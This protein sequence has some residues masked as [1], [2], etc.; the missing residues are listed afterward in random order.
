MSPRT[1]LAG[2]ILLSALPLLIVEMFPSWLKLVM[3]PASY[4]V[5]HNIVEFF[6]IMVSL[7]MFG[8]GW[9]TYDQS[10]NRH[11]LFLS[12]AFLAI[13][14]MDFMH[15]MSMPAMP[16]FITPNLPNKSVQFWI[17][18]RLLQAVAFLI[19]AF[20]YPEKPSRWLS[21]GILMTSVLLLCLVVF[22]GIIFFPTDMPAAFVVGVGLTP[23]KKFSEYLIILLLCVATA[24][25][26][27]RMARTGYRLLLYY[28]AAFVISIFS[29]IPFALYTRMFDTYN[30]LGHIY[31]VAAFSLIYYG[32]FKA[33]V[34]EPYIKLAEMGEELKR[35]IA[36]RL[37]AEQE[38]QKHRDHLEELV[39]GRT[40]QLEAA[41][42]QLQGEIAERGRME[43]A[44]RESEERLRFALETSHTG[45]WD[46]DLVDHTTFRSL[47]HDRIF[48]YAELLPQ[49]TYE[50]FLEHV[51]PED[52]AMVSAKF[53]RAVDS[54]SDWSFE[55][56][57]RR[58][59][60]QVRW[61]WAAGHHRR[62]GGDLLRRMAGVVQDITERKQ[63]EEALRQRTL[64]LQQLTETL[65][66]E[67]QERTE[68]LEAMNEELRKEIDQC[69]R[70]DIEL[71]KSQEDLRRLSLE[72]LNAHEKE[73]RL[74]AREIHDSIGSS[75]VAAKFKVETALTEVAD[76]SP[77]ITTALKNV[78]PIVQGAIDDAR[79]I[80]MNLR[81]SMLDDLGLLATIRWLCRQFESTYSDIRIRQSI[82][83]DEDEVS[84]S[85]KTVVFRVL[86]EGLNNI[87]KHSKTK[88]VMLLLRK[89]G[90]VLK[91]VIRDYGQ[92]FDLSKA[93]SP[94]GTGHGFGLKSMRE[95][96]ELSGG[97]FDI[98]SI[99]GKGT[100][101][102][103]SWPLN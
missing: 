41:N 30:V 98:K 47:E 16:A 49:W 43:E 90:H 45:A 32:I 54:Q 68:Q 84:D 46:L 95:R 59:D 70:I 50:M 89:A 1:I 34:K 44:L 48:G 92:G 25:Y 66:Q 77:E 51:L 33:S 26:W 27:K 69:Q 18:V 42:A 9:Y 58:T 52:R 80:Q 24:A 39:K 37:L 71:R 28:L 53:Q 97:S 8:L 103:A 38:L 65:E 61:I 12:T 81:P 5:F 17:A 86:Q 7:S 62:D 23:F 100:I 20:V 64:E 14:I 72:L 36:E 85:L 6:S 4:L 79:R 76:K 2:T 31:K 10:K 35:D 19:S 73:R 94:S 91:L 74:V 22:T 3:D 101:I 56:R 15:T 13:G 57:I 55:C 29:E 87:A 21:K 75:L 78:I 99:K 82:E 40:G 102:R 83:I 11:A 63:A 93:Q 60:G 88:V 67:V 96:T